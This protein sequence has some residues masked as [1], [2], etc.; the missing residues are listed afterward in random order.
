MDIYLSD[1][2]MKSRDYITDEC[3]EKWKTR[4][5]GREIIKR[6]ALRIMRTLCL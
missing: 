3:Y 1:V 5:I 6:D 4:S 2:N